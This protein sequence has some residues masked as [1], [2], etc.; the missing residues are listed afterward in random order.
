MHCRQA[1]THLHAGVEAQEVGL[2]AVGKI[3]PFP[4]ICERSSSGWLSLTVP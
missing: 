4:G 3:T 2:D 1:D